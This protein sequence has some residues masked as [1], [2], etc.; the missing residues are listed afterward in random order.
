M[1]LPDF[2]KFEPLNRL[3]NQMGIADD[4]Y[5]SFSL[6]INLSPVLTAEELSKILTG[7]GVELNF[8]EWDVLPDSTLA[9]KGHRVLVYIRDVRVMG[10][11]ITEP[12]YHLC[13]CKTLIKMSQDGRSDRY[14][15]S[16]QSDGWFK[17]N[18]TRENK[19]IGEEKRRLHVCKNCLDGLR[20]KGFS[21]KGM[22]EHKKQRFV[23]EFVPDDFFE[24]Y[25]RSLHAVT[26][27]YDSDTAPLNEYPPDF[28]AISERLRHEMG[29][30]CQKCG[31]VLFAPHLRR[32]LHVHHIN[33][34]RSDN[35][36]QNLKILC[37][38][39]HAE[40]PQHS[41]MRKSPAYA[42]FIKFQS[43]ITRS[44]HDQKSAR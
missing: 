36:R 16:A 2:L 31:Q 42:E 4:H 19:T 40:E 8:N 20:F 24:L 29:W 44:F 3:R 33:G 17:I 6:E 21:L 1:K 28:P 10:D 7:E 35:T 27:K 22:S 26:P 32:Y 23:S 12:K 5:G 38:A 34:N 15:V 43:S 9:Y 25:P 18:F 14:V 41:H 39:C 30:Q 11:R 37:V 13:N